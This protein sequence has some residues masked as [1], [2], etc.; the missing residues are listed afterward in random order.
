MTHTHTNGNT[1]TERHNRGTHNREIHNRETHTER[2][3]HREKRNRETHNRERHNRETH[4]R[5]T[6]NRETHN[7][8]THSREIRNR[9]TNTQKDTQQR[10][11]HRHATERHTL[12]RDTHT[13]GDTHTHRDTHAETDTE[14]SHIVSSLILCL[15]VDLLLVEGLAVGLSAVGGCC[16]A[17]AVLRCSVAICYKCRPLSCPSQLS[18][19]VL[20]SVSPARGGSGGWIVGCWR[21][22]L[23]AGGGTLLRCDL[24]QISLFEL[25]L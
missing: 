19:I 24:P 23:G 14:L 22:L 25:S 8:E 6:H 16:P 21:V 5:Q 10:D 11:T 15:A 9:E 2:H 20:C 12:E 7:R 13:H 4:D 17:W 18:H 3:P 1:H